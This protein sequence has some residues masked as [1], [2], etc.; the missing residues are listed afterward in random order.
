MVTNLPRMGEYRASSGGLLE[1]KAA[2]AQILKSM[3]ACNL[4]EF[5]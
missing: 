2:N 1:A 5:D 4:G 3:N